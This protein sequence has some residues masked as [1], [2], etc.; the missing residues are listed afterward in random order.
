MYPQLLIIATL[1][2]S[3]KADQKTRIQTSLITGLKM[4]GPQKMGVKKKNKIA[5]GKPLMLDQISQSSSAAKSQASKI[6]H[7]SVVSNIVKSD[8]SS[9]KRLRLIEK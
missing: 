8:K 4:E 3:Q 1:C 2:K 5:P 9:G 6:S 7:D